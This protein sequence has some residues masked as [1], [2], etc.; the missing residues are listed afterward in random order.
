MVQELAYPASQVSPKILTTRR[1]V[2]HFLLK[3]RAALVVPTEVSVQVLNAPPALLLVV[4]ARDRH[5]MTAPCAPL[6]P[7][8]STAI[9][10]KPTVMVSVKGQTE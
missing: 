4:L 8:S 3:L 1:N 2:M 6:A 9:V 7:T 5:R 10:S